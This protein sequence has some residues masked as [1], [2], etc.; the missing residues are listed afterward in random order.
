MSYVIKVLWKIVHF[1]LHCDEFIGDKGR[2]L[3]M[4][5]YIEGTEGWMA[6]RRNKGGEG[7]VGLLFGRSVAGVKKNVLVRIDRLLWEM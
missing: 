3:V 7:R 6:E 4:I 2:L 5:E 1:L